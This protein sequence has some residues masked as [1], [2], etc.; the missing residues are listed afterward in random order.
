[1]NLP[2]PGVREVEEDEVEEDEV[3]EEGIN[4]SAG[5]FQVSEVYIDEYVVYF[6]I[7][8]PMVRGVVNGAAPIWGLKV[9]HILFYFVWASEISKDASGSKSWCITRARCLWCN[10]RYDST[11]RIKQ[12]NHLGQTEIRPSEFDDRGILYVHFDLTRL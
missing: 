5:T 7:G 9:G 4:T 3:E 10:L 11:I 2:D 12:E 8:K 1:M 6:G